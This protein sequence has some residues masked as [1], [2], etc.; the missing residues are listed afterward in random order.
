MR[1]WKGHCG[2][3]GFQSFI[4]ID[5]VT[6]IITVNE[7]TTEFTHNTHLLCCCHAV[8]NFHKL[9]VKC[10]NCKKNYWFYGNHFTL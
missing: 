4:F 2:Q 8:A 3:A 10:K 1:D 7:T 5:R 6:S 9:I